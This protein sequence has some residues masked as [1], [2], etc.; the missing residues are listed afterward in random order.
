MRLS[1]AVKQLAPSPTLAVKAAANALAAQGID[2]LDMSLGEPDMPTPDAIRDAGKQAI[3]DGWTRYTAVAGMMP[4]RQRIAAYLGE[5]WGMSYEAEEILVS[6]GA[7]QCLYH[8]IQS[9]VGPGD[10]VLIPAPYWVSY[11]AQVELA[12]GTSVIVPCR[13][14]DDF[15]IDPDAIAAAI[16]PY[17]RMLIINNPNNPTGAV[18]DRDRIEAIA[19]LV[20]RH[21]LWLLSD[22][23][24]NKLVYGDAEA[25]SPLQINPGL[26][27]QTVLVNGFSKA[28]AMTG[29]RMGY[30]AAPLPVIKAAIAA[31]GAV[32]SGANTIAQRAAL[33]ALDLE[34][35]V[36][37][38]MRQTFATRCELMQA[39]FQQIPDLRIPRPR[40]AFY[41][42][43]DFSAYLHRKAP[44]GEI[45]EDT[46]QLCQYLLHEA[47]V[48]AVP[49]EAFGAPGTVRFSYA[50][51][52]DTIQ[53]VI[54]NVGAALARLT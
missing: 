35:A 16:T 53:Q 23:I 12:G 48:A 15:Q 33:A 43:P 4:L 2:V 47:H 11:T 46:V 14:E 24:Y 19:E 50:T 6:T 49:G 45:I 52:T 10:E 29:W 17:T 26:K 41:L 21:D 38:S 51:D 28:Y 3:D 30:M 13:V 20:A 36:I 7:K 1:Y 31:Q 40:G 32:T 25:V 34:P 8:A 22:E 18:Y 39:G 37:E 5:Q 27:G 42:M 9:L 44:S 54:D